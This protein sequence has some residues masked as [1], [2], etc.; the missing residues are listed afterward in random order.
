[1]ENGIGLSM[2]EE[3]ANLDFNSARLEKRFIKTMETLAGQP[4]KSIWFS[5][6]NRA[7]AKAIY[8]MLGN[9][10][11]DREKILQAHREATV[12]RMAESEKTI[13]AVQDTTSLNYTA[14]AKMEGTGYIS[15]NALGVNIHSRLA[16]TVDGLALGV[17]AQSPYNRNQPNNNE[18]AHDSKKLRALEDK[19]SF[20]WVQTLGEST[21]GV[22]SGVHIVT[23][24]GREGDMYE[25]FDEAERWRAGVSHTDSAEPKNGKK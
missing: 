2:Q 25:L 19:E 3:F 14:Q 12:R 22:P 21:V 1:M 8:R 6:E 10:G 9:D 16:V 5:S 4:D 11:L 17:L 15:G 24:C 13:L 18:G 20:R 7:E 23:V